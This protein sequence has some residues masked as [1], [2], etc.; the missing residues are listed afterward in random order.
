MAAR[1]PAPMDVAPPVAMPSIAISNGVVPEPSTMPAAGV[2]RAGVVVVV[3]DVD[4]TRDA[5][6]GADDNG[7][8]GG[9]LGAVGYPAVGADAQGAEGGGA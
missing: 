5:H 8:G 6:V 9:K 4:A 1:S 7:W 2:G 3:D